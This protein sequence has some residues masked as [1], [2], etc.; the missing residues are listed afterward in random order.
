[1]DMASLMHS[2]TRL[3]KQGGVYVDNLDVGTG[4]FEIEMPDERRYRIT[5]ESLTRDGGR[6]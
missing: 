6:D 5:V 2:L 3:F 4:S 1:M